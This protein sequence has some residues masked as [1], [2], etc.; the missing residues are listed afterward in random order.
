MADLLSIF[1][2]VDIPDEVKTSLR[3]A[4]DKVISDGY[5]SKSIYKD[6][7]N[8]LKT[9]TE[10]L[11]TVESKL[12]AAEMLQEQYDQL[13]GEVDKSR[14]TEHLTKKLQGLGANPKY[15]DLLLKGVDFS[16]LEFGDNGEAKNAED[17]LKPVTEMYPDMFGK[18][19]T[20]GPDVATPPVVGQPSQQI[21]KMSTAISGLNDHRIVR[22]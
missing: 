21:P 2:G 6:K 12:V 13:K 18:Q 8:E 3:K 10:N 9:A 11:S 14:R 4:F 15:I 19:V 17:L 22:K 5:V 16:K 20:S 7:V 1:D